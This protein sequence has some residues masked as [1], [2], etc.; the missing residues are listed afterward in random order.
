MTV[1]V[2]DLGGTRMRAALVEGARIVIQAEAPTPANDGVGPVIDGLCAL[3]RGL[4]G[5]GAAG[6]CAPGPLDV[7]RGLML[8]PPTLRGWQDVPV[9]ALLSER[10]GLPVQLE[11]DANAAAMGEY[12]HGAGRGAGVLVFA[13]VSTGIGGGIVVD[14]KMLRGRGGLAGEIGHM[15]ID[16]A[17]PECFC[18]RTGCFEALAAGTALARRAGRDPRAVIADARAGDAAA[19]GHLAVHG[20]LLGRGFSN[21]LH[22]FAPDVLVVGGGLSN[23]FDLLEPHIRQGIEENAMPAYRDTPVMRA[24]LGEAAG[25]IGMAHLL[26]EKVHG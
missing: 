2:F 7:T 12:A 13:T 24:A 26:E 18:G 19:L 22:L 1:L 17:G 25:L 14:G 11:N 6:I 15:K 21:L 3:A 16:S 8:A 10:L 9:A 5:A 20:R 23:A 4:G